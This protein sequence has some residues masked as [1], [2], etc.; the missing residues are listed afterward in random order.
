[1]RNEPR[2]LKL[3][4]NVWPDLC[5]VRLGARFAQTKVR[6]ESVAALKN[7]ED[8]KNKTVD[9]NHAWIAKNKNTYNDWLENNQKIEHWLS[10]KSEIAIDQKNCF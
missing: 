9:F 2:L 10:L 5:W 7:F 6:F 4:Q 3:S 8:C 1:M